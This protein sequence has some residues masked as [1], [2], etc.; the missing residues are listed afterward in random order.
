MLENVPADNEIIGSGWRRST[1]QLT[2]VDC[3]ALRLGKPRRSL[4]DL[5]PLYLP[6]SL[7]HQ[8]K[9]HTGGTTDFKHPACL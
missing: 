4:G 9:K 2:Y 8:A 3:K 5:D 7:G 6:T 1:V